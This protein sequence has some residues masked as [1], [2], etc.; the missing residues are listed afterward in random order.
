MK[1]FLSNSELPLN[2]IIPTEL[3]QIFFRGDSFT[4][5]NNHYL[6]ISLFLL[7]RLIH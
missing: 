6:Q 7:H 1:I 4:N 3:D 2:I 5:G